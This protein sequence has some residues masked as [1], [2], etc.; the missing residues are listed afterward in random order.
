MNERIRI[1]LLAALPQEYAYFKKVTG[2][3][4]KISGGPFP[5]F[6][7]SSRDL[8]MIL[9]E[10]GMGKQRI[11]EALACI[12]KLNRP[13]LIVCFGFA[14]GLSKEFGIGEV[15]LARDFILWNGSRSCIEEEFHL[16][17]SS[18]LIRFCDDMKIG[19][20]RIITVDRPESKQRLSELLENDLFIVDMESYY[21]AEFASAEMVPIVCFRA[22]SDGIDDEIN[23]DIETITDGLGRVRPWKILRA[24]LK[25]PRLMV[26]FHDLWRGSRK[27]ALRLGKALAAFLSLPVLDIDGMIAGSR[28]W[29][30]SVPSS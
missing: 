19:R 20:C 17:P 11:N 7:S 14:G 3:W 4:E 30:G 10:T 22:V 16:E 5:M 2:P 15:F 1:V 18:E 24:V 23:F 25:E 6:R 8:D 28:L 9:I 29:K 26:S 27:A 21:L 13:D 12:V